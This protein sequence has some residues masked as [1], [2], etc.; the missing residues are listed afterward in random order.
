MI[1]TCVDRNF[2]EEAGEW[3]AW[4]VTCHSWW[5]SRARHQCM[6]LHVHQWDKTLGHF[7]CWLSLSL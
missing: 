3:T 6:F 2:A 7:N 4:S 1:S 5:N